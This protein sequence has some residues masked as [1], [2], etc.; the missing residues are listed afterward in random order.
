MV[1]SSPPKCCN[2]EGLYRDVD[3]IALRF[4]KEKFSDRNS[5][6]SFFSVLLPYCTLQD[7]PN[8]A[9]HFKKFKLTKDL[10]KMLWFIHNGGKFPAFVDS[11]C[12]LLV[13]KLHGDESDF[14]MSGVNLLEAIKEAEAN[15]LKGCSHKKLKDK[16]IPESKAK[17]LHTLIKPV[18]DVTTCSSEWVKNPRDVSEMNPDMI[19]FE[20]CLEISLNDLDLTGAGTLDPEPLSNRRYATQTVCDLSTIA[21]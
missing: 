17:R 10:D 6:C 14:K 21:L 1:V 4:L 15:L 16:E 8:E 20:D 7:I 18:Q 13:P 11:A 12:A 2:E 5:R 9:K 19:N 3:V